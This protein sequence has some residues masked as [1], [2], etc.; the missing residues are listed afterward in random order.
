MFKPKENLRNLSYAELL[1]Y[2]N[3]LFEELAIRHNHYNAFDNFLD[4]CINGFCFN[5]DKDLMERIRKTYSIEER[6]MFSEMVQLWILIMN[7]RVP[8]NNSFHDFFGNYYEEKA[9]SKQQG[10]AQY[11]TPE[12]ICHL[13]VSL[14]NVSE[15]STYVH[16]PACGSGRFNLAMHANNHK[17]IHHANDLDMT[18]AKMTALNFLIHGVKGVVTCEDALILKKSFKGAFIVNYDHVLQIEYID[19][20]NLAY[21]VLKAIFP[22]SKPLLNIDFQKLE[23]SNLHIN[24]TEQ[25]SSLSEL[26]KQLSLF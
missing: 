17:L 23:E 3:S 13:V 18:C 26:N 25:V 20:V 2:F 24:A 4:I 19:D 1:K 16:E 7:K 5:Y 6:Q 8:D 14:V 22:S 12:P 9:M 21:S 11:F 15:S 10:F